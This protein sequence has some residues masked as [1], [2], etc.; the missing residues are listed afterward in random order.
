M[1]LILPVKVEAQFGF[2]HAG[3]VIIWQARPTHAR[4]VN[5]ITQTH[6]LL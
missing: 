4:A 5:L 1:P 2:L 6:P 3:R